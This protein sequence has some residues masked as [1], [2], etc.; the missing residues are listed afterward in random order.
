MLYLIKLSSEPRPQSNSLSFDEV[1]TVSGGVLP[2][3]VAYWS[4]GIASTAL[5]AGSA[6]VAG[7]TVGYAANRD[8]DSS[9][10]S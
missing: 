5:A 6:W 4:I 9:G 2:I 7:A 10:D 1:E 3:V 8:S